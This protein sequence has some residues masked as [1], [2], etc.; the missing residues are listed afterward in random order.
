[1]TSGKAL[2]LS[3]FL[4]FTLGS[5]KALPQDSAAVVFNV[6]II[7]DVPRELPKLLRK[8]FAYRVYLGCKPLEE[9]NPLVVLCKW[10]DPSTPGIDVMLG[11]V[12]LHGNIYGLGEIY[13][14]GKRS[15]KTWHVDD[16]CV[17]HDT[18]YAKIALCD[19]VSNYFQDAYC[20]APAPRPAENDMVLRHM[21]QA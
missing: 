11:A 6:I 5:G 15:T 14:Q 4:S 20:V 7:K 10:D 17:I 1:M 9:N 16:P 8:I 12:W 2:F 13:W 21:Y 3:L 19:F 18:V